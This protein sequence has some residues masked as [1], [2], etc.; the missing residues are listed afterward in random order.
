MGPRSA[1]DVLSKHLIMPLISLAHVSFYSADP[2]SELEENDLEKVRTD[3]E[4]SVRSLS[5][6]AHVTY[7][8]SIFFSL[9]LSSEAR[10]QDRS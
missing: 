6:I 7:S 3:G 1:A 5:S 4:Q 10:G 8:C 9:G 2:V